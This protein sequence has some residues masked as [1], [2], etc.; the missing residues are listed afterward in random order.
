MIAELIEKLRGTKPQ[1]FEWTEKKGVYSLE[2]FK[3]QA[4]I[5]QH[6]LTVAGYNPNN[7]AV[8]KPITEEQRKGMMFLGCKGPLEETLSD[9]L[10]M[11][12]REEGQDGYFPSFRAYFLNGEFKYGSGHIPMDGDLF[13]MER[14]FHNLEEFKA[15]M[16]EYFEFKRY[17]QFAAFFTRSNLPEQQ[18]EAVRAL[19]E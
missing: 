10:F 4:Q 6:C 3:D 8:I 13:S 9:Y 19:L 16:T 5:A 14:D 7:P 15:R 2:I 1:Y 11:I 17:G 18:R 12:E